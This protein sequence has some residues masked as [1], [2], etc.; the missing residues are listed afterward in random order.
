MVMVGFSRESTEAVVE[1]T[2][3]GA[4]AVCLFHLRPRHIYRN[5]GAV[6]VA[7]QLTTPMKKL[8]DKMELVQTGNLDVTVP[9]D[10]LQNCW[11]VRAAT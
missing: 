8:K 2:N 9:N 3:E 6:A 7:K 4:Q 10:S 1:D 5:R 11:E